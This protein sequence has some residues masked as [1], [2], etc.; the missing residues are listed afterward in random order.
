MA[1]AIDVA[2]LLEHIVRKGDDRLEP[3]RIFGRARCRVV[4]RALS[5]VTGERTRD[6]QLKLMVASLP[7]VVHALAQQVLR[8]A[9]GPHF[10]L[11][12]RR[13]EP[14]QAHPVR[15][16]GVTWIVRENLM[17]QVAL[18]ALTGL[19]MGD[20]GGLVTAQYQE[21]VRVCAE[22][23]LPHFFRRIAAL[24]VNLFPLHTPLRLVGALA[25][26]AS[27]VHMRCDDGHAF[28][29]HSQHVIRP[30]Q[31]VIRRVTLQMNNDEVQPFG[32][33]QLKTVGPVAGDF[34]RTP[35]TA[36]VVPAIPRPVGKA[37]GAEMPLKQRRITRFQDHI[38]VTDG[39]AVRHAPMKS[40]HALAGNTPLARLVPV[41]DVPHVADEDN[42][43]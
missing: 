3:P 26:N 5:T 2:T 32:R 39:K 6:V 36:L 20:G 11:A 18:P 43:L 12:P 24:T 41:H 4:C 29:V 10:K 37:F 23:F 27:Q 34:R 31:H 14:K 35:R 38:V 25:R 40:V 15:I 30:R 19:M 22:R 13:N 8:R 28:P 7:Q 42:A 16:I 33:E 1:C 21:E 17:H 9:V